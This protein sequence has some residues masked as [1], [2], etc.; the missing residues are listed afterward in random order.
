MFFSR[1]FS[2]ISLVMIFSF[3]TL[4][5]QLILPIHLR[6]YI[7][8]ASI[9]CSRRDKIDILD[10]VKA[11]ETYVKIEKTNLFSILI[12]V[13]IFSLLKARNLILC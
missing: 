11:S 9:L 3:V 13:D 8:N 1:D 7:S 10:K 4:S 6:Q 2:V 5:F 12:F